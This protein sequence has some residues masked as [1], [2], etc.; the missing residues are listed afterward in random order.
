MIG[1]VLAPCVVEIFNWLPDISTLSVVLPGISKSTSAVLDSDSAP[2]NSCN[3][4][5]L[6]SLLTF[7]DFS[8]WPILMRNIFES[9]AVSTL[10]PL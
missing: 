7:V 1:V 5:P 6:E 10:V 8:K 4:A 3:F 9:V 2:A